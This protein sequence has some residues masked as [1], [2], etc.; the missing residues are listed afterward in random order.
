MNKEIKSFIETYFPLYKEELK[1]IEIN[2]NEEYSNENIFTHLLRL[3][4]KNNIEEVV[5]Y[6]PKTI[7]NR[8]EELIKGFNFVLSDKNYLNNHK[9]IYKSDYSLSL[10]IDYLK[11]VDKV[12]YEL[13]LELT[14]YNKLFLGENDFVNDILEKELSEHKHWNKLIMKQGLLKEE[15][16]K[17]STNEKQRGE[18]IKN[19][20]QNDLSFYA[21]DKKFKPYY[22]KLKKEILTKKLIEWDILKVEKELNELI[23]NP[24]IYDIRTKEF[25]DFRLRYNKL[26]Y[27][28]NQYYYTF[29]AKYS[30]KIDKYMTDYIYHIGEKIY[31]I[32]HKT[33]WDSINTLSSLNFNVIEDELKEYLRLWNTLTNIKETYKHN[34]WAKDI[35]DKDLKYVYNANKSLSANIEYINAKLHKILID[36]KEIK[37]KGIF[38]KEGY[39]DNFEVIEPKLIEAFK[40]KDIEINRIKTSYEGVKL[41][42]KLDVCLARRFYD[43]VLN[44]N[45]GA[46]YEIKNPFSEKE[47]STLDKDIP[48]LAAFL[49]TKKNGKYSLPQLQGYKNDFELHKILNKKYKQIIE[50]CFNEKDE[51]AKEQEEINI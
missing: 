4:T 30:K 37:E 10:L 16:D 24:N 31:N 26:L 22:D 3:W 34:V 47:M 8:K 51:I 29:E 46:L 38:V 1:E 41:G 44:R 14:D 33:E 48:N 17:Q 2:E 19:M 6:L 32:N 5:K 21:N 13:I 45:E 7:K 27:W 43:E 11:K 36:I 12:S 35:N 9:M 23:N 25:K 49:I 28:K 42:E 50:N 20:M 39:K 18:F 15:I 40:N